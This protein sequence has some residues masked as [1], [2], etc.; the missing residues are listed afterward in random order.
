[1]SMTANS[2]G[3]ADTL[4]FSQTLSAWIYPVCGRDGLLAERARC[5]RKH[6]GAC[7]DAYCHHNDH[8]LLL[9]V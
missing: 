4:P 3:V 1:M 9:H 8:I 2:G 6:C 7:T 5:K